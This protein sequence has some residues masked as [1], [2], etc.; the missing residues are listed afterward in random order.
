MIKNKV[1]MTIATLL[2]IIVIEMALMNIATFASLAMV[3][4]DYSNYIVLL[5]VRIAMMIVPL[6]GGWGVVNL[7]YNK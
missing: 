5:A 4:G 1:M 3:N 6:I 2:V 7:W